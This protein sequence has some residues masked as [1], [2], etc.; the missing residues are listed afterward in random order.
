MVTVLFIKLDTINL[1]LHKVD[2]VKEQIPK[3]YKTTQSDKCIIKGKVTKIPS[4]CSLQL[5]DTASCV[6]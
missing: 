6:C 1:T 3:R 4:S 5:Y 2:S